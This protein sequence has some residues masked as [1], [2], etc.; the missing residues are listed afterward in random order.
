MLYHLDV[1]SCYGH[2]HPLSVQTVFYHMAAA[3]AIR[4]TIGNRLMKVLISWTFM[5]VE[6]HQ[7]RKLGC[8][9]VL[10]YLSHNIHPFRRAFRTVP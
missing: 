10:Y 7:V 4:E 1:N 8:I 9:L 3:A 5:A 6:I 2:T